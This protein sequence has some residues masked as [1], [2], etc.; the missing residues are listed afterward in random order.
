MDYDE[1]VIYADDS[2]ERNDKFL[3]DMMK[4]INDSFDKE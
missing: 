4:K 3:K 2:N 1:F